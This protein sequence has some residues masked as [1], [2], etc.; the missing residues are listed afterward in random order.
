[1]SR[2]GFE[3]SKYLQRQELNKKWQDL[4]KEDAGSGIAC[5]LGYRNLHMSP[6]PHSTVQTTVVNVLTEML[7]QALIP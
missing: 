6:P 2:M 1:M 5:R 7:T 4:G 3:S